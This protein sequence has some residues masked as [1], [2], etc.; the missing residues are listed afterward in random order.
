MVEHDSPGQRARELSAER[1]DP[2]RH[3]GC[4]RP[5]RCC[6]QLEAHAIGLIQVL[7]LIHARCLPSLV[8]LRSF[9]LALSGTCYHAPTLAAGSDELHLYRWA[10]PTPCL[11]ITPSR[12]ASDPVGDAAR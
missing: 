8:S 5:Q 11:W 6:Q 1:R 7:W 9:Q 10:S 4:V 2:R 12:L 3:I